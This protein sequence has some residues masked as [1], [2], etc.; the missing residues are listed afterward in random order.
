MN[1]LKDNR[2]D[3]KNSDEQHENTDLI[4][5]SKILKYFNERHKKNLYFQFL[6]VKFKM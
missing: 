2:E 3:C 6:N 5:L 4:D 1:K